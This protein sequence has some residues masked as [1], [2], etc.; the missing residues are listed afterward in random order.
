MAVYTRIT[1]ND[2]GDFVARYDIG[3]VKS[4]TGIVQGV[5]NSNYMLRTGRGNFILTL[6]EKRVRVDDLPFYL[7]LLSYLAAQGFPCPIPIADRDAAIIGT[8][9]GRPAAIVSFL[10][11]RGADCRKTTPER[12]AAIG[13]ICARL[14]RDADGFGLTRPNDLALPHWRHLFDPLV[15]N[16]DSLKAGLSNFIENE[17]SFLEAHWPEA[18]PAGVVH[19]D[20]FPDNVF[21]KGPD[22][23]G[24]ID[25]YFACNDFLAWDLAVCI[26]AWCFSPDG[27]FLAQNAR[28]LL[29][30]YQDTR[31][32]L[33]AERTALPIMSRGAALRFMLTR[34][35]D[36]FH[37]PDDA[38][39]NRKNPLDLLPLIQFH[40]TVSDSNAYGLN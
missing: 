31:Q 28:S 37:T 12:C 10:E 21:F 33:P 14:H 36:W 30:G 7:G 4:C 3:G 25:F 13:N 34:L 9:A 5:E 11:G 23:T 26:N 1:D 40:R 39:T 8:L 27:S 22:L 32:L 16:A 17:L 2:L 35:H 20:L 24:V 29:K 19:A 15:V 6:Y 18:L 38:L